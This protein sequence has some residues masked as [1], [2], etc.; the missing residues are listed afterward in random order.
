MTDP[1]EKWRTG[2]AQSVFDEGPPPPCPPRFNMARHT[3]AASAAARPHATALIVASNPDAPPH[4]EW[5]FAALEAAVLRTAAGLRALGLCRGER[6]MLRLGN[7]SDFPVLYFGTIAA[8]GV[9][10]PTSSQL[11][12]AEAGKAATEAEARFIALSDDLPIEGAPAR[13]TL[14]STTDV[15]DL[16]KAE[17]L[18]WDDPAGDT[19]ADDPAF[20][21]FTSGSAGRPKGVLH[22]QRAGWARRMMWRG[23]Y[24]LTP[25]DHGLHAGAFNWTYTLG[26]GLTDPWAVGAATMIYDG[27]ADPTVWG[28]LVQR[29]EASVFAAAPGVFRQVLSRGGDLNQFKGLRCALT[30]GEKLSPALFEHWTEATAV[31]L[32]EAL[33]MS[34][35]S[36][37]I[38]AGPDAPPRPGFAGRPQKGRRVAILSEDASAP[39]PRGEPGLLAVSRRDPGLMLGYWRRPDE[40]A[41]AM[42]GE[43]F[44]TGDRARMDADGYVAFEGRADDLMNAGGYR[45]TPAEV[46]E[47]ICSHPDIAECGAVEA[48]ISD[49]LSIIVAHVVP[50]PG[51]TLDD[52]MLNA[53]AEAVLA[54]YK[55]PKA[56][57]VADSLP[58]TGNGKLRRSVL[59]EKG[60]PKRG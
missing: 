32:Y 54:R 4:E 51:A 57:V 7:V 3:L 22:A 6:V 23:W 25:E 16:R 5:S 19:M 58:R 53:H 44:L 9:A 56:W 45:V 34:E 37:Y 14:L 43:W 17:P 28:R 15:A 59:R 42:R 38:S 29:F 47:A 10:V 60:V 20:L 41:A 46:E 26:A 52:A 35:L 13:A 33:G 40:T 18:G 50:A 21:V 11:T 48:R 24:G 12:P 27:P 55:R 8:G 30:A 39:V 36:T 2:A 31:P 49:D 1:A